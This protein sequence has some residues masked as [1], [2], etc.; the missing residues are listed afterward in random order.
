MKLGRHILATV[1]LAGAV[2][3]IYAQQKRDGLGEPAKPWHIDEW[4][5]GE[6]IKLADGKDKNVFVVIFWATSDPHSTAAIPRITEM[7]KKYADQGVEFIAVTRESADKVKTFVEEQGDKITFRVA[8]DSASN[9]TRLYFQSVHNREIPHAFVID[10]AGIMVWHGH[11]MGALDKTIA[12]VLDGSYDI[13]TGRRLERAR[14]MATLYIQLAGS[15]GKSEKCDEVGK[16]V[17]EYGRDDVMLMNDFAWRIV[18]ESGLVKRD[19]PLALE[20]AQ[21]AFEGTKGKN[22][23]VLDTYARVLFESGK[24]DEAIVKQRAA[25][26]LARNEQSRQE[27][28]K[29]LDKYEKAAAAD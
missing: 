16:L 14:G 20:A 12:G 5:K 3:S 28:Q 11:P 13:E 23:N 22:P 8:A 17:V 4:V 19:L 18:T 9:T 24:K 26:G 25:V 21:A 6:R 2:G 29:N 1:L 10:K 7:H 27:F 15:P